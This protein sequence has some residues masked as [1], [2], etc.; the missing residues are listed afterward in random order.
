MILSWLEHPLLIEVLTRKRFETEESEVSWVQL[1]SEP[2][3]NSLANLLGVSFP[4]AIVYVSLKT[5]NKA[6]GFSSFAPFFLK[7]KF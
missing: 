6:I 4:R 7:N 5:L 3:P 2:I 1:S